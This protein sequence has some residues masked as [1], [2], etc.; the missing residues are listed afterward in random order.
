MLDWFDGKAGLTES[1]ISINQ[2]WSVV[3][4]LFN[5]PDFDNSLK[6][7][8]FEKMSEIDSSMTKKNHEF[9][10]KAMASTPEQFTAMFTHA[11]QA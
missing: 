6:W 5:S 8:Y 11:L 1:P 7:Q 4:C 3:S 9:K 10:F 2:R